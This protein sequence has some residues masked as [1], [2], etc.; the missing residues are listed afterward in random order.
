MGDLFMKVYFVANSRKVCSS[1]E[2]AVAQAV[3][4]MGVGY[5][6]NNERYEVSKPMV[7]ENRWGDKRLVV[8]IYDKETQRLRAKTRKIETIDFDKEKYI[9]PV[10]YLGRF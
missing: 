8:T 7:V 5:F 6:K 4:D 3:K 2:Q 9:N 1:I 10:E